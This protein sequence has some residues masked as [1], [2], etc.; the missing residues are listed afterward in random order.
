MGDKHEVPAG[1][2]LSSL[3]R[4]LDINTN[5]TCQTRIPNSNLNN[6]FADD[7]IICRYCQWHAFRR[8]THH[9][10]AWAQ[11]GCPVVHGWALVGGMA[12]GGTRVPGRWPY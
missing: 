12:G 2:R 1:D 7:N 3:R 5:N 10:Q 4:E 6:R 8:F 11:G 9:G